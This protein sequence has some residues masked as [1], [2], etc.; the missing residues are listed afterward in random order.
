M[1][2]DPGARSGGPRLRVGRGAIAVEE[3]LL[4]DLGSL[5]ASSTAEIGWLTEPVVVVVPSQSLRLHVAARL[6]ERRGRAV[7]GLEVVT[8]HALASGILVRRGER[9]PAAAPL[10]PV[11]VRRFARRERALRASL[12][13]LVDGYGALVGTVRDLL[14]AGFE[15]THAEA[16]AELLAEQGTGAE[17]ERARAVVRTAAAV[18]AEIERSGHG[19]EARLLR[20]AAELLREAPEGALPARGVLVHGFADATGVATDLIEALARQRGAWVYLDLPPDPAAGGREDA[21]G[22]FGR[23]FRDRLAGVAPP[24]SAS[25]TPPVAGKVELFRAPGI[26]AEVR[27]VARRVRSLLDAGTPPEGIG[28][29]A[30]D[31]APYRDTLQIDFRRLA[32]PFS[33]LATAGSR[34]AAGR[35]VALLAELLRRGGAVPAEVWL[36]AAPDLADFD[37][38]LACHALGAPRL[39][40]VAALDLAAILP[41]G[42]DLPLPVRRGLAESDASGEGEGRPVA[43]HRRVRGARIREVLAR[44]AVMVRQLERWPATAR[45]AAHLESLRHLLRDGLRWREETA[46][47]ADV[48][49]GLDH[50][51][52]TLPS[53]MEL[54][55]EEFVLLVGA[56]LDGIGAT[57]LGGAGAGIQVLTVV[58]ARGRTF[59]HLFVVGLNR[60]VFPRPI[61]EDP[62]LPDRLRL[63]IERD[64]LPQMPI[65]RQG[66]DE[67]RFLFAQLLS[68]SPRVTLSFL[69]CDDDG[70]AR[71][72]SPLVERLRLAGVGGEVPLVGEALALEAPATPRPA[73][74]SAILAGLHGSRE[75]FARVLEV[76][77]AEAWGAGATPSPAAL[78]A[79]RLAVLEEID[80]D[81]RTAAG[82]ARAA[83]LGPYFGFL[84]PPSVAAD[85]R[86]RDPA[87]TTAEDMARCPWQAFLRSLLRVE[88]PPDALAA[89]PGVDPPLLGRAVHR[90]LERI[91][92]DAAPG[93]AAR[94]EEAL[95][96]SPVAVA[97]PEPERLA[98]ILGE[99][100]GELVRAVGPPLPGLATVVG[101]QARPFLATA[102]RCAFAGGASMVLGAEVEGNVGLA[103]AAGRERALPFRADRAEA[104]AGRVVLTDF[105]TGTYPWDA[106]DAG[107]RRE[108]LRE[109][110]AGGTAL[111]AAAY[112]S[113]D[114]GGATVGRYLFLAPDLDDERRSCEVGGSDRDILDAFAD[115]VRVVLRCWDEGS[116]FPRLEEPDRQEEP[117]RCSVCEV[118]EACLRGDSGA[119]RRLAAWVG[120]ERGQ[121]PDAPAAAS[122]LA[123]WRLAGRSRG[124]S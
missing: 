61:G 116:F 24:E 32:V 22:E 84:G 76:A 65:K 119:R 120:R 91:V 33:A 90:V 101:E 114:P 100:C 110:V 40:D 48:A 107:R 3:L 31:L 9:P 96:A 87:V 10:L 47:A 7:T 92:R 13:S 106:A 55:R 18:A 85:P 20:R 94:L 17:G 58:E 77:C 34:S 86:R 2:G 11:L 1:T 50:L 60:D 89:L 124:G 64:A 42:A 35:R 82:R 112:A 44:A 26:R 51:A 14:D 38:R 113:A 108:K 99:V 21:A 67:E 70:R 62:L 83:T 43:P 6:V 88:P 71:P 104:A 8:L 103:D 5:L 68:A 56:V 81:R 54:A 37:L 41:R 105:K 73:L 45:L 63:A 16:L 97:W 39:T 118:R 72:P 111:Q 95:A 15:A 19:G 36:A 12:D 98:A 57:R 53:A 93:V 102:E 30:R 122:L 49:V 29:V 25:G 59:S 115:A 52:R 117:R 28:V 66:F 80:P 46:G 75:E 121:P 74:E 79:G 109:A 78:A 4:A 27:E 23:R 123:L 69:A